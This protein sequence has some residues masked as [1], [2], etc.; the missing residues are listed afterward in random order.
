MGIRQRLFRD[1]V[2]LAENLVREFHEVYPS[3]MVPL[4]TARA[5]S[6]R[7]RG[8]NRL[9]ETVAEHHAVKPIGI[10][11]RIVFARAFQRAL[12]AHAYPA[13]FN[14]EITTKLL[15]RLALSGKQAAG[16]QR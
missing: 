3:A 4:T 2:Q 9:L 13:A 7:E 5:R 14:R 15:V 1:T 11:R 6:L 10:F 16:G 12:K 8:I